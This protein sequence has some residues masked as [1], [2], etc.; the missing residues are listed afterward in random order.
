MVSDRM[1]PR[2]QQLQLC[3]SASGVRCRRLSFARGGEPPR[4]SISVASAYPAPQHITGNDSLVTWARGIVLVCNDHRFLSPPVSSR[5]GASS[6]HKLPLF[7]RR[8]PAQRTS[9]RCLA[10]PNGVLDEMTPRDGGRASVAAFLP[11]GRTL[12]VPS[13][14]PSRLLFLASSAA[15]LE[16]SESEKGYASILLASCVARATHLALAFASARH[17]SHSPLTR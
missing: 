1:P 16:D 5:P 7:G 8:G 4:H 9:D 11:R 13:A 6:S 3:K 2:P 14:M 17:R 15:V 10:S 12:I